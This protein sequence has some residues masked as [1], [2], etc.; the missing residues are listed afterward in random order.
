MTLLCGIFLTFSLNDEIFCIILSIPHNNVMDPNNVMPRFIN[1]RVFRV[2]VVMTFF[3]LLRLL[4]SVGPTPK[5]DDPNTYQ[6][7]RAFIIRLI[8]TTLGAIRTVQEGLT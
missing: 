6:R 7:N 3:S 8:I 4:F 5:G 2:G 1:F